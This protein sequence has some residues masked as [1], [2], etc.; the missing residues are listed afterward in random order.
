MTRL[1]VRAP[2]AWL[3]PG[4]I[5]E[6]A[7][8]VCDGGPHHVRGARH[9]DRRRRRGAGGRRVPDAGG[10]RPPRAHRALGSRR[11]AAERCDGRPRPGVAAR[12]HLPARRRVGDAVVPRAVDPRGRRDADR[13]RR[14]P[15]E[16]RLGARRH[17]SR[18]HGTRRRRRGGGRPRRPRRDRDQGLAERRGR[19]HPDRRRADGHL[20]RG[21]PA[22][23]A[24]HGPRAGRRSGGAR[25]GRGLRRARAHAVDTAV[26][27]GDRDAPP[28]GCGSCRRSTSIRT[29]ATRRRSARRSTTSGGSTRPGA[30]SSTAPTWGTGR[31][32]PASTRARSCCS[33]TPV[34][35]PRRSCRRWSGRR[36][37]STLRPI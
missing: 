8:V 15:D 37:T 18:A 5:V 2:F 12:A 16:G 10:G 19:P 27:R 24:R 4:R 20:R 13:T 36:S 30:R 11:G 32:P 33:A 31:S 22:R 1:S 35:S 29:A 7:Q 23:P 25:A 3:A 26:G 21:P 28:R 34:S 6:D 14:I 17:R 9:V